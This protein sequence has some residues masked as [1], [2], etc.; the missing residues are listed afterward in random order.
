MKML[1]GHRVLGML[2]A[3]FMLPATV[4]AADNVITNIQCN[5]N[6]VPVMTEEGTWTCGEPL[7]DDTNAQTICSGDKVLNGSGA[8]VSLP[9]DTVIQDTN[10]AS[11]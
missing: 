6:E 1:C 7:Q 2:F 3:V 5:V 8:C 9:V 4:F 10:G 11:E